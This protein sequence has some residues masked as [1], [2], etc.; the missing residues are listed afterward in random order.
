MQGIQIKTT[1]VKSR[2]SLLVS[3]TFSPCLFS[4]ECTSGHTVKVANPLCS[5]LNII[6]WSRQILA[7]WLRGGNGRTGMRLDAVVFA[8]GLIKVKQLPVHTDFHAA[9]VVG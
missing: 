7:D 1:E 4:Q 9:V 5:N 3:F 8:D 2:P 6:F